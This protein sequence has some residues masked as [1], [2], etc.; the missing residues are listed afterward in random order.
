MHPNFPSAADNVY[1][2]A[3]SVSCTVVETKAR[4]EMTRA[5]LHAAFVYHAHINQLIKV[6]R[7]GRVAAW[8][9]NL[10]L[11]GPMPIELPTS[12]QA[13]Q[14]GKLIGSLLSAVFTAQGAT[15]R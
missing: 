12:E 10:H 7:L 1:P 3:L 14:Q 13:Q 11:P 2:F 5:T 9:P 8:P 6:G 4:R 15:P